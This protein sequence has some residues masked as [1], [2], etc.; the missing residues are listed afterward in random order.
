MP[1]TVT[2]VNAGGG[3][4]ITIRIKTPVGKS[5]DPVVPEDP[6]PVPQTALHTASIARGGPSPLEAD[7]GLPRLCIRPYFSV[8]PELPSS[9]PGS[10]AGK[11]SPCFSPHNPFPNEPKSC[12]GTSSFPATLR[13]CLN[14]FASPRPERGKVPRK[15][16]VGLGRAREAAAALI[17]RLR[18]WGSS[19]N[20]Y[21]RIS[22]MWPAPP[23]GHPLAEKK[24]SAE[25]ETPPCD[26]IPRVV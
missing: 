22:E 7:N 26:A 13:S 14:S 24:G 20:Q 19:S 4:M 5:L 17:K 21:P 2:T 16:R 15:S 8:K 11:A 23:R 3:V 9:G 18:E 10:P 6:T 12:R 1:T 25:R